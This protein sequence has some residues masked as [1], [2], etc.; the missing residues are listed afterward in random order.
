MTSPV[1]VR[2]SLDR[3]VVAITEIYAH[4]VCD[5]TTTFEIDPPSVEEVARRRGDI[6]TRELP[7]LVAEVESVVAGYAYAVPYR[8]RLA[9]RFSVEDSIYIHPAYVGQGIGRLLL[10][11]VIEAC[12]QSGYR[13][14]LAVIGGSDNAKSIGLHTAMGFV[15]AGLLRSV[16]FKFGRWLDSVLM[17]RGLGSGDATSGE[18]A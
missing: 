7:H 1:T 4:Y 18:E 9:Y 10:G 5:S 2:A 16:G 13:Q 17:Q 3:D 15:P 6:L 8:P 11:A 14:M 12:E